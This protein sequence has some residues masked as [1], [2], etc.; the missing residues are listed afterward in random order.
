MGRKAGII[1]DRCWAWM[2]ES[3]GINMI[4][5]GP[6]QYIMDSIPMKEPPPQHPKWG[7]SGAKK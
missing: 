2:L 3:Y 7:N 5:V 4:R 1:F 6:D